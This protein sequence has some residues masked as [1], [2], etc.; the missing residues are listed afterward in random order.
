MR[1]T[2]WGDVAERFLCGAQPRGWVTYVSMPIFWI[3]LFVS[4]G[5]TSK[6]YWFCWPNGKTAWVYS[7]LCHPPMPLCHYDGAGL[8]IHWQHVHS[9][10]AEEVFGDNLFKVNRV[11]V[12]WLFLKTGTK[13]PI[14]CVERFW[15]KAEKNFAIHVLSHNPEVNR[16]RR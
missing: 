11:S 13:M 5:L 8:F 1:G 4:L 3:L 10:F 7:W 15:A 2:W 6:D 9:V 14:V 16:F 12:L